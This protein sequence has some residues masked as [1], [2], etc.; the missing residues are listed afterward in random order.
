MKI[1][2]SGTYT[3]QERLRQKA[4]DLVRMGHIVDA[5]WLREVKKPA[6][7]TEEE[8]CR[9][10][11]FEDLA[12][13]VACDCLILDNYGNSTS[14]GRYCEWGIAV[15]PGACK[16][17][18]WIGDRKGVFSHLADRFFPDWDECLAWMRESKV[19]L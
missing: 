13:V 6:F 12:Q 7:L 1:Y 3:A 16:L 17:K 9:F 11:G 14:G 19:G 10:R 18:I 15:A 5:Y 4:E 2:I 8:F